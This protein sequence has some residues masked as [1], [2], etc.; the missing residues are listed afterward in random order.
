[1]HWPQPKVSKRYA[2]REFWVLLSFLE[3]RTVANVGKSYSVWLNPELVQ[4]GGV[5]PRRA[6]AVGSDTALVFALARDRF[7]GDRQVVL[8]LGTAWIGDLMLDGGDFVVL[9]RP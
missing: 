9:V 6:R 8:D 1:M 2:A 7:D 3:N 5:S 4:I